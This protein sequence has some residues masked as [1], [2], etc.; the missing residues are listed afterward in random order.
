MVESEIDF[1]ETKK[2]ELVR[3]LKEKGS[4]VVAFSGGV[5]SS[6]VAALAYEAL[7]QRSLA[8]TIDSPLLPR[9]ELEDAKNIINEIGIKHAI[10]GLNELET[11]S[12]CTNPRNRCYICKKLRFEKLK[13]VAGKEGYQVVAEGTNFSDLGQYR[14]GLRAAE[15]IGVYRPLIEAG[16]SK[17]DTRRM[18]RLMDLSNAG[19]P[20]S[21]C[22]ATRIPYGQVLT[23][24]KLGRID[25]AENFIRELTGV[26]VLRV[27]DHGDIARIEVGRGER[28]LFYDECF[29][30][31]IA[32]KLKQLS[33]EFVTLDL[34]GYR[35]GSY[36]EA[37]SS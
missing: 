32:Q 4:V 3:E 24:E 7:G 19:K 31:T 1:L 10:V 26:K 8:V 15:E 13:E 35:F 16:L 23:A 34:E 20:A 5:D 21:S 12:F 11:P 33:Y 9:G 28:C 2:R 37:L 18:A 27:R 6:V 29:M 36:D 17:A 14:P 30:T 22:L 25:D